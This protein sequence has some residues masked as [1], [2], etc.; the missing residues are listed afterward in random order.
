MKFKSLGKFE[1]YTPPEPLGKT[2][3][4]R[5]GEGI[6]WYSI[7]WDKARMANNVYALTANNGDVV[8]AS[9]QGEMLFPDGLTVWQVPKGSAPADI[10]TAGIRAKIVDGV[11]TVDYVAIAEAQRNSL[12][13]A[14]KN[15]I[16]T[17]QTKLALGRTLTE[18]DKSKL[19]AWFD[20]IDA[21]D[22][23]DANK[24]PDINWPTPPAD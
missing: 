19:N 10:F 23:L 14:A 12:L 1:R 22:A 24:A 21:L 7:S 2:N 17:W 11:Y 13:N 9:K 6:D 15:K 20:Y 4:L 5:N 18:D 8:C 16:I 3:Y